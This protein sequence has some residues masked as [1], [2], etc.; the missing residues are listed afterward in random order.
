MNKRHGKPEQREVWL[1]VFPKQGENR[2]GTVAD[3][4]KPPQAF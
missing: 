1:V 3:A 2:N 4:T